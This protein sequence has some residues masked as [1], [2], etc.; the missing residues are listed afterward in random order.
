[1]HF[2]RDDKETRVVATKSSWCK[3]ENQS[4]IDKACK[5]KSDI[6]GPKYDTTTEWSVT[7]L[8]PG[9]GKWAKAA[10]TTFT[11]QVMNT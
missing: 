5:D 3:E 2:Y 1:M 4:F 10:R 6:P 8:L 7:K 9:R 11:S